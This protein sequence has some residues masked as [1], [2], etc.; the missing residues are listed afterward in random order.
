MFIFCTISLPEY[1]EQIDSTDLLAPTAPTVPVAGQDLRAGQ[2]LLLHIAT[3]L[4][5]EKKGSRKRCQSYCTKNLAPK[6]L[7]FELKYL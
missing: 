2:V 6:L 5:V 7:N 4:S 3:V 1:S